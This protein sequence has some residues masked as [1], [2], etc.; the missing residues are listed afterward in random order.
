[1]RQIYSLTILTI[2]LSVISAYFSGIVVDDEIEITKDQLA[3]FD[4]Y[5]SR[6]VKSN[7]YETSFDLYDVYSNPDQNVLLNRKLLENSS[8]SLFSSNDDCFK[9]LPSNQNVNVYE[10]AYVWEE[11]RCGVRE[12][13][14][15]TFFVKPPYMHFSGNSYAFLAL[16]NGRFSKKAIVKLLPY[17][18]V[19]ELSE[20]KNYLNELPSPFKYFESPRILSKVRDNKEFFVQDKKVFYLSRGFVN[21][22]GKKFYVY[23]LSDFQNYL[24]DTMFRIEAK[25]IGAKCISISDDFCLKFSVSYFIKNVD[26]RKIYLFITSLLSTLVVFY[27]LLQRFKEQKLE[28]ERKNLAI[29]L[30]SHEFRT[31]VASMMLTLENIK[32]KILHFEPETQNEILRIS[33]DVHRLYRLT[34]M[35]KNYLST[36]N[37]FIDF[38][39]QE[40]ELNDYIESFIEDKDYEVS[41]INSAKP[42]T[43]KLDSYWLGVCIKNLIENAINHGIAPVTIS[44]HEE[45]DCIFIK[46]AD[47]GKIDIKLSELTKDFYKGNKSEGTGLGL[48]IVKKII[49]GMGGDML[50]ENNPTAFILKMKRE[51]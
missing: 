35:S 11:F 49:K 23:N 19:Q 26:K 17:F 39:L 1:M 40:I 5:I 41:F 14:R 24:K 45:K 9:K 30:L 4:G 16:K 27:F 28:D 22:F 51:V 2:I 33:S 8:N 34:M 38:N 36:K 48:G 50:L 32:N 44:I 25:T 37:K 43:T 6:F 3:Q 18:N 20:V 7:K 42:I 10:K 29:R 13:L 21:F 12:T 15:F 31:P 46:V 47:S